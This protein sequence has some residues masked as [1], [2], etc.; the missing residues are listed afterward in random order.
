FGSKTLTLTITDPNGEYCQGYILEKQVGNGDFSVVY[1]SEDPTSRTYSDTLNLT[2]ANKIR[3]RVRTKLAD[4]TLSEYSNEIGYDTSEG[5]TFQYGLVNVFNVGWNS[6]YFKQPYASFPTIIVGSPTNK[7]SSIQFC[8]RAKLIS[9]T[10]RFNL[11]IIPWSYQ[12]VSSISQAETVPYIVTAPGNYDF[13]GLKAEAGK[14]TV[15]GSWSQ[16]TFKVPFDTIPVVFVTGVTSPT[17]YAVTARVRNVTK[18]GFEVK[19]L[20]ESAITTILPSEYVAYFAITPGT[21]AVNNKKLIV[22]KTSNNAISAV[23]NTINYGDS[24]ATPLFIAQM[25]TCNDDTV[26]AT[27]RSLLISN[28]YANVMKQRER[29]CGVVTMSRETGG[30]M[31]I[32]TASYIPTSINNQVVREALSFYPNPASDKLYLNDSFPGGLA[33]DVYNL[34]GM[35]VKRTVIFGNQLDISDIPAGYYLLKTPLHKAAK[36]V[37]L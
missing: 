5:S 13:D 8:S 37:K 3:Y 30:W 18:T 29:S 1:E 7:N 20:K 21:G 26:A 14:S 32:D 27:L 28:K 23:Y 9:Y 17:T 16:V 19:R 12:N 31:A 22:G 4:S 35:L 33:I 2:L 6:I 24:L 36:F 10:S 25:Q 15:S 34:F 11:Q